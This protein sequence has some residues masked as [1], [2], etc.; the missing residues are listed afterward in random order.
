MFKSFA[1]NLTFK[2]RL[3]CFQNPFE[4]YM[5][6][7]DAGTGMDPKK[8]IMIPSEGDSRIIGCSCESDY[9]EVVWFKVEKGGVHKCD[10]GYYFKL[11]HHDPMDESIKPFYGS[12]LG[13]GQSQ[14]NRGRLLH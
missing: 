14:Y 4:T 9:K 11:I 2:I 12:G 13:S 1:M 10:C 7:P 6:K 5:I 8:P 3:F